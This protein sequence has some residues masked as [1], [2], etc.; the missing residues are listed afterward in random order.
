MDIDIDADDEQG[1]QLDMDIDANDVEA[2]HSAH[3]YAS[4]NKT[5]LKKLCKKRD[6]ISSVTRL[7]CVGGSRIRPIW[8][9]GPRRN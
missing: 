1:E 4:M 2:E 7:R 5:Q 9:I 6:F 8:T 3:D